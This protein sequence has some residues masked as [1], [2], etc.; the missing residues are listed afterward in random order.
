M[1]KAFVHQTPLISLRLSFGKQTP[2]RNY[3]EPTGKPSSPAPGPH[4]TEASKCHRLGWVAPYLLAPKESPKSKIRMPRN[5]PDLVSLQETLTKAELELCP[6]GLSA[7]V[8]CR[9][10]TS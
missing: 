6:I 3:T 4:Q 10:L 2:L 8:F 5:G 1:Q 7:N 9:F